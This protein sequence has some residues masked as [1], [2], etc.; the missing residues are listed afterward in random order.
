MMACLQE[1]ESMS[2]GRSVET[3]TLTFS[4]SLINLKKKVL[5]IPQTWKHPVNFGLIGE[6]DS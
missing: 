5:N 2:T 4:Q 1:E 6:L 3:P